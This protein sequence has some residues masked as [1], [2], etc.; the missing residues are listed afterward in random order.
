M[1]APAAYAPTEWTPDE[2]TG[3]EEDPRQDSDATSIDVQLPAVLHEPSKTL[4]HSPAAGYNE[5]VAY[6]WPVVRNEAGSA[7]LAHIDQGLA[8]D[9]FI[10]HHRRALNPGPDQREYHGRE[11]AP[12]LYKSRDWAFQARQVLEGTFSRAP[13]IGLEQSTQPVTGDPASQVSADGQQWAVRLRRDD[14]ISSTTEVELARPDGSVSEPSLAPELGQPMNTESRIIE[15]DVLGVSGTQQH[16]VVQWDP[17]PSAESLALDYQVEHSFNGGGFQS[18]ELGNLISTFAV[19]RVEE[20]YQKMDETDILDVRV[21][22]R[23]V[24][25]GTSE[26]AFHKVQLV[27]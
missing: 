10:V 5:E 22:A 26:W 27:N 16:A 1:P 14:L 20:V 9:P 8:A 25:G 17:P 23:G 7:Y 2:T 12:A 18:Y 3:E 4:T 19:I 24:L 21:R 13:G 15:I 11:W 6:G